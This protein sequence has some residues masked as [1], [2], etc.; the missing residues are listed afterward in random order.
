[1]KPKIPRGYRRVREGAYLKPGDKIQDCNG[2]WFRSAVAERIK[3]VKVG[4]HT[5]RPGRIYIRR[6]ARRGRK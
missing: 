1:M 5:A 4:D 6:A 2:Y 3:H